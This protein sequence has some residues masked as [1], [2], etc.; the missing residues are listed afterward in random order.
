MPVP[1]LVHEEVDRPMMTI[2]TKRM[3]TGLLLRVVTLE[4]G[5]H[6]AGLP[7]GGLVAEETQ[8]GEVDPWLRQWDASGH[9]TTITVCFQTRIQNSESRLTETDRRPSGATTWCQDHWWRRRQPQR[10]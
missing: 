7:L 8:E 10:A 1:V 2:M 4:V 5:Q 6:E 9:W 3:T